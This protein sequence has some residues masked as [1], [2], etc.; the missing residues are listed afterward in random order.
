MAKEHSIAMEELGNTAYEEGKECKNN[1]LKEH[2]AY[3]ACY[4]FLCRVDVAAELEQSDFK[5]RDL[6]FLID[7][8]FKGYEGEKNKELTSKAIE[9][10]RNS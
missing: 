9:V 5:G 8:F 6:C 3:E 2:L 10:L 4:Q 7:Q 1:G